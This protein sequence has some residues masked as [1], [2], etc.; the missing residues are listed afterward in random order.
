MDERE[1]KKAATHAESY[2]ITKS[3]EKPFS[4]YHR[5]KEKVLFFHFIFPLFHFIEFQLQFQQLEA[6]KKML[7]ELENK[8]KEQPRLFKANPVPDFVSRPVSV[9]EDDKE[10]EVTL[11]SLLSPFHNLVKRNKEWV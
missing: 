10:R 4:F 1:K 8:P 2:A 6:T 5:D 11:P 9:A 7:E 3:L